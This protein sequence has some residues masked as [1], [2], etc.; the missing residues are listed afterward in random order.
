MRRDHLVEHV[1]DHLHRVESIV[2]RRRAELAGRRPSSPSGLEIVNS[3]D[4]LR[5]WSHNEI[6]AVLRVAAGGPGALREWVMLRAG[7]RL[8]ELRLEDD[9][10]RRA[11]TAAE[12]ERI[13]V[14]RFESGKAGVPVMEALKFAPK[15][16]DVEIWLRRQLRVIELSEP[17]AGD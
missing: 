7:E 9:D 15:K 10:R 13:R 17:E 12:V 5:Q 3:E 16:Q 11:A 4:E 8:V 14:A 1:L 2:E 6:Q